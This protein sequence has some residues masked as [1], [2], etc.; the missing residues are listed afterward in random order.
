MIMR[1]FVLSILFTLASGQDSCPDGW[2]D[3][4][5]LGCFLFQ[6]EQLH[7][8]WLQALEYCEEQVRKEVKYT[9]LEN[10]SRTSWVNL[11]LDCE[12]TE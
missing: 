8:S 3:G 12:L 7:L 10:L 9:E 11:E 1:H 4:G 2:V 6:T 5:S